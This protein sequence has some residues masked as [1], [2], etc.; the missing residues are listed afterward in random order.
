MK[1]SKMS[2][3]LLVI[4]ILAFSSAC[5]Q[6]TP[7]E[8]PSTSTT[9]EKTTSASQAQTGA[10][11][12]IVITDFAGRDVTLEK[13]PERV[14]V[15]TS[16]WAEILHILGLDDKI[17][18]IGNYVPNNPY[19]PK[20]VKQKPAVG[21]TFKGLNWESAASL[22]PDLII[23]D[24]YG[25]KYKD[26]ETIE[27]A[28]E[29]GI[30]VIALTAQSV[31]DNIK[32]VELLGKVFGKE[33]KAEELSN[34][35]K[36]KLEEMNK[37]VSQIPADKKKNVLVIGAPKDINGPITV[38]AK[39]SAWASIVELVGAHNLAFDKEFD[40][41]WPKLDLEKIIAY[42]GEEADVIIVTS[43]NQEKLEKA[44][45]EIKNDPRWGEIK[46]VKEGHIYGILTGSKGFLDWGPRI[47]VGVYQMGGLIYPEYYPKWQKLAD[48][49]L[50]QFYDESFY[51]TIRDS[52]GRE[53]KI[54]KRG[55]RAVVLN[56]YYELIIYALGAYDHVVGV[57]K[58][59]WKNPTI[60]VLMEKVKIPKD[61]PN[62]GSLWSGVDLEMLEVLNPD[63]VIVWAYGEA[64]IDKIQHIEEATGIPVI[65]IDFKT[66]D[67][68]YNGIKLFGEI[69]NKEEKAKEIVNS[70]KEEIEE[71]TSRTSEI[72]PDKKVRVFLTY[73]IKDNMMVS[74]GKGGINTQILQM[75]NAIPVTENFSQK[76]P[77][78]SLEQL[79]TLN[80][81]VIILFYR[82]MKEPSPES[83]YNDP[84]WQDLK[85]VKERKICDLRG[86]VEKG[87][88]GWEPAGI[89]LRVLAL[90]ECCYPD[91]LKDIDFN[92]TA[93]RLFNKFY[94]I[95]Y[96]EMER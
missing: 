49:L 92:A 83:L 79:Y 96:R 89:P 75:I 57:G 73:E 34:W 24:W 60:Q 12:K 26:K 19:I 7:M 39:G 36:S 5:V 54:P 77:K 42:W 58:Y 66:I 71:V 56:S 91:K 11:E 82:H 69:F 53:V 47:V 14:I 62:L 32:V 67:D 23:V 87:F 84:N 4:S 43:F 90:A 63:C 27:K 1:S 20:K 46:A 38:Y 74:E 40:T 17:V 6:K 70:I 88:G 51:K 13:V 48:E 10:Q 65:A 61:M 52:L 37:I 44:V 45:E 78:V 59:H 95:S 81:D 3:A 93:E 21:S 25:G 55:V 9:Q 72:P 31:E 2:L 68:F 29:L 18:G 33:E 35:M 76:Y 15:L 86:Y 30:P 85:A 16:Y 80:P 64:D 28:Q 41:Q 22:E 50:Q 8:T 94:G